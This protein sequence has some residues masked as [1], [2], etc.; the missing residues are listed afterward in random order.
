METAAMHNVS[1]EQVY[2]LCGC[3][4]S[5]LLDTVLVNK[6]SRNRYNEELSKHQHILFS[7]KVNCN[8]NREEKMQH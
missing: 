1:G 4:F 5:P 8:I 3:T 2:C 6:L 7:V